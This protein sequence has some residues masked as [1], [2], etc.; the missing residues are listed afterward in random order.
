M[1]D[2]MK[3]V[4]GPSRLAADARGGIK[5]KLIINYVRQVCLHDYTSL[6]SIKVYIPHMI[7]YTHRHEQ[8]SRRHPST[9]PATH[10]GPTYRPPPCAVT[11]LRLAQISD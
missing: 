5:T 2:A 6:H 8:S 10:S 9:C 1:R 11:R 3:P 7:S 4:L